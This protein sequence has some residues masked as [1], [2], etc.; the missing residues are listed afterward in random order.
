MRV[1]TLRIG[2]CFSVL[3]TIL[4]LIVYLEP[5]EV[6]FVQPQSCCCFCPPA[7]TQPMP[8]MA[9]PRKGDIIMRVSELADATSRTRKNTPQR[10]NG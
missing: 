7:L 8:H 3:N 4:P 9:R 2:V 10:T 1:S 6:V 5:T